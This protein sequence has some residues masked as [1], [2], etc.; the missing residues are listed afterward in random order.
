[1]AATLWKHGSVLS[2][3]VT[4]I[5]DAPVLDLTYTPEAGKISAGKINTKQDIKVD[6]AVAIGTTDVMEYTTFVH[7]PCDPACGWNEPAPLDGSPAFLLH[8]NTCSL[9]ITKG[10]GVADESYVFDILKDGTKYSEVTIWGNGSKT[11]YELPVGNYTIQENTG[12]S[13]RYTANNG[14]GVNLNAGSPTGSIACLNTK[15]INKWLNGYSPVVTN[16]FGV[17]H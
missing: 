16:I 9:T 15:S 1:M 17:S 11:I 13:W 2:T 5:G 8:V 4:M 7:T 14:S 6:V 3:D 12:W 10:G